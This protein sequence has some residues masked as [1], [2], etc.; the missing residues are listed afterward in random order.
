LCVCVLGIPTMPLV[1]VI[2]LL[3]FGPVLM[4]WYFRFSI[5]KY[6]KVHMEWCMCLHIFII[7]N[8]ISMKYPFAFY[9]TFFSQKC[10]FRSRYTYILKNENITPSEQ[11]QNSKVKSQ[12]QEA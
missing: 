6:Y 12:K 5:Y 1:S 8:F 7:N 11:V 9:G 10:I 4:V 2:L 3:N